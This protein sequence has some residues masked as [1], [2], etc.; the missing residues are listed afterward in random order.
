MKT[1]RTYE[2]N[3]ER[4][5]IAASRRSDRNLEARVESARRASEIHKQRTG[6]SLCS[7]EQDVI[8]EEIYEEEEDDLPMR[9]R[10]LTAHLQTQN[11][12][13]N[14]R[15]QSYLLN[16]VAMR[17]AVGNVAV[18]GMQVNDGFPPNA[19]F[20][21]PDYMKMPQQQ[22][23]PPFHGQMMPTKTYNRATSNYRQ[24]SRP[25]SVA[26]TQNVPRFK[27]EHS[28]SAQSSPVNSKPVDNQRILF[29]VYNA[30]PVTPVSQQFQVPSPTYTSAA[31]SR[32]GSNSNKASVSPQQVSTPTDQK[33]PQ[34]PRNE[35]L[36]SLSS[37]GFGRQMNACMN[38]I[39]MTLPMES[40]QMLAE[41]SVLDS[42]M[43]MMFSQQT[44]SYNP[45]A[46]P[47]NNAIQSY[48]GRNQTLLPPSIDTSFGAFAS[49]NFMA[50]PQLL[51]IDPSYT[52]QF[53]HGGGTVSDL[54]Y[55]SD[56]LKSGF[57][58]SG[59]VTPQ[60]LEFN[61]ANFARL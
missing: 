32:T 53:E 49:S 38:P 14:R 19:G 47:R 33:Q 2:E 51:Y 6:R 46:K 7:T 58:V 15:F 29:P 37:A 40:Q 8:D 60:D 42:S 12:D 55:G 52:P 9:Y 41:P 36:T 16:N 13:F 31:M 26:I 61:R 28:Q 21:N 27:E 18:N 59:N 11:A 23:Q 44:Y 4:A 17:Q 35:M 30:L 5:Y 56:M 24:H 57:D 45:N 10:R 3:Q 39:S 22:Q 50:S 1:E 20:T 34:R 43:S 48:D 54:G 25:L